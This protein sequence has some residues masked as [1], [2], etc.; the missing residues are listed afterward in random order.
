MD[1]H[2]KIMLT[3]NL[4][5]SKQYGLFTLLGPTSCEALRVKILWVK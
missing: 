1:Y 4:L 3:T 5:T 2:I